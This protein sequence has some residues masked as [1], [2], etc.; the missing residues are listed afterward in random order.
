MLHD[1]LL[2]LSGQ[3]STLF[4]PAESKAEGLDFPLLSPSE[5]ELLKKAG[6]LSKLHRALRLHLDAITT[7]HGSPI[8]KAVSAA[9]INGELA[10]FQ[11]K[12][13]DVEEAILTKDS[14]IVGAYNIVPLAGVIGEFDEW[15]RLMEWLWLL[16]CFIL[17]END[18]TSR[19]RACSGSELINKLRKEAQTGYP[20]IEDAALHLSRIA[21][22]AWLLQLST[23]LL[24]GQLPTHGG[25]DFFIHSTGDAKGI[26]PIFEVDELLLPNFVTLETATSVAFIG[27]SLGQI[28]SRRLGSISSKAQKVKTELDLLS[29]HQKILSSLKLPISTAGFSG[30]TSAIRLSLSR[31]V[32]QRLLPLEDVLQLLT[33][34][35]EFFLLGRGEFAMSLIQEAETRLQ[36]RNRQSLKQSSKDSLRGLVMKDG[37]VSAVLTKALMPVSAFLHEDDDMDDS[38]EMARDMI[39]LSVT[40]PFSSRSDAKGAENLPQVSRVA[41]N[42]F[43]LPNPTYLHLLIRPPFDLFITLPEVEIYS[44]LHS[45]LLSIQRGHHHLADLWKQSSIRRN[46]PTPLGPPRSC[47]PS[48]Q[49]TIRLMRA[50]TAKRQVQMRKVW[51]TCGAALFLLGEMGEYLEGQVIMESWDHLMRWI[52]KKEKPQTQPSDSFHPP[53]VSVARLADSTRSLALDPTKSAAEDD[54]VPHDPATLSNAHRIF[55]SSLARSLLITD[56]PFT[57]QLRELLKS[58]D[59]IIAQI[60]RLQTI[61]RNMDLEE[62]EGVVDALANYTQDH[63]QCQLEL[64]RA[65]KRVDMGCKEVVNRLRAFGDGRVDDQVL[66][67]SSQENGEYV[68]FKGAR[69]ERLLMK[70]D[71][72]RSVEGSDGDADFDDE[73]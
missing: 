40:K 51:A 43:L 42:D 52:H 60:L 34:F 15:T 3:P 26:G 31:N 55:L 2:S 28:R 48:G 63:S 68:P 19:S 35:R 33:L 39:R 7:R 53:T 73:Y 12:I 45:Y 24:Y 69:I 62:D 59:D 25:S 58:I 67:A 66:S 37:E 14:A 17:P 27:K 4:D 10:N 70:L 6:R 44:A 20:D 49:K 50:R 61:Q 46:H 47:T 57:T 32:L 41:F 54:E 56:V 9:I 11:K 23:W 8:C 13:L 65:R 38:T 29:S 72:G 18:T 71:F 64:D 30:A 22:K 1:I 36:S 5:R 21:E 16:A